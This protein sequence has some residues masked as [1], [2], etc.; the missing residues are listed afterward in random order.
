MG[1]APVLRLRIGYVR[2]TYGVLA[3]Y[4]GTGAEQR[5]IVS[6]LDHVGHLVIETRLSHTVRIQYAKDFGI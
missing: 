1:S 5:E 3:R 4:L 6:G 2:P